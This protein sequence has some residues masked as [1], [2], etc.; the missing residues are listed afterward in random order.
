MAWRNYGRECPYHP[1]TL[2]QEGF[3]YGCQIYLDHREGK[4]DASQNQETAKQVEMAGVSRAESLRK[5]H[6]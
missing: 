1:L 4:L 2:C 6:D 5:G 3:C